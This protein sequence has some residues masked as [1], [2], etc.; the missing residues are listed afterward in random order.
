MRESN[1]Y[2]INHVYSEPLGPGNPTG[3]PRGRLNSVRWS[4][5]VEGELVRRPFRAVLVRHSCRVWAQ[6]PASK[7]KKAGRTQPNMP[8]DKR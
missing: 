3:F 2:P 8:E 5:G 7:N 1:F 4:S 6:M